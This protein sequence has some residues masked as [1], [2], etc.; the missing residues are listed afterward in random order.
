MKLTP[1]RA[2]ES[3]PHQSDPAR[4]RR[5]LLGSLLVV[6]LAAVAFGAVFTV[7]DGRP[8]RYK[9]EQVVGVVSE[10]PADVVLSASRRWAAVAGSDAFRYQLATTH[11]LPSD[12]YVSLGVVQAEAAPVITISVEGVD[13]EQADQRLALVTEELVRAS[14]E[15]DARFPITALTPSAPVPVEALPSWVFAAGAAL[16]VLGAGGV[17]VHELVRPPG[18]HQRR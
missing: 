9:A 13:Q 2:T 10:Q 11:Q 5:A 1:A 14:A 8:P 18:S 7:L 15:A 12:T 6:L 3:S 16:V 17:L 4:R